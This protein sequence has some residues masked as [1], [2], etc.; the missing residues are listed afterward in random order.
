ML[1]A[2]LK[3]ARDKY[4]PDFSNPSDRTAAATESAREWLETH[5]IGDI[6]PYESYDEKTKLFINKNSI[7]FVLEANPLMGAGDKVHNQLERLIKNLL[8][9]ESSIQFIMYASPKVSNLL[10]KWE[11]PRKNQGGNFIKLAAERRKLFEE[12]ALPKLDSYKAPVRNYRLIISFSAAE[13]N[14]NGVTKDKYV[15]ILRQINTLFKMAKISTNVWNP[16]DLLSFCHDILNFKLSTTS[17]KR[18]WNKHQNLSEQVVS[19]NNL[20]HVEDSALI[21]GNNEAEMRTYSIDRYPDQSRYLFQMADLIGDAEDD[22]MQIPC[23]FIIHYGVHVLK[24]KLMRARIEAKTSNGERMEGHEKLLKY[25]PSFGREV[26]EGKYTRKLLEE[27]HRAVR[28]HFQVL[29]MSSPDLIDDAEQS[30]LNLY[31]NQEITLLQ[32]RYTVLPMVLS[33]LPM[34]W[35]SGMYETNVMFKASKTTMSQEPANFMPI[36]AEWKGTAWPGMILI[37][38]RGQPHYFHPRNSESNYNIS[39]VGTSGSGKSVAMQE[40]AV[41]T[42]GNGGAVYVMD[43]GRSFKK[44]CELFEGEFIDFSR[45]SK[46]C[47]NPFSTIP[48]DPEEIEDAHIMAKSIIGTMARPIRGIDEL[49]DTYIEQAISEV[50]DRKRQKTTITDIAEVLKAKDDKVSKDLGELLFPYTDRGNYGRFFNGEANIKLNNRFI[51]FEFEE[52][53]K[54]PDLCSVVLQVLSTIVTNRIYLGDRSQ[55]TN[56]ILDEAWSFLNTEIAGKFV[57]AAARRMRKYEGS[58]ITGTQDL[59]DFMSN[60]TAKATFKNSAWKLLL[61][62]NNDSIES[63]EDSLLPQNAHFK[64]TWKSVENRKGEFSEIMIVKEDNYSVGRLFLDPF[65]LMLYS[66]EGNTYGFINKLREEGLSMSEAVER[67]YQEFYG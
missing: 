30:L 17:S 60:A 46:I 59:E 62:T 6:L 53:Q 7:G 1:E 63:I 54:R 38:R 11:T 20:L 65:S 44:T 33:S 22:Y 55:F 21:F 36:L 45:K 41:S 58:L 4:F 27:N 12:K 2:I 8:P 64:D 5:S 56:L 61:Q 67:A 3:K 15:K 32:D 40:I 18:K 42:L 16:N 47:I 24:S 13:K 48:D 31:N 49:E 66:T 28:T 37:G 34:T 23:P 26:A 43:V 52:L 10:D 29:L 14:Y 9:E 57:E 19:K 50:W 25:L 39:L 51:V 35:G